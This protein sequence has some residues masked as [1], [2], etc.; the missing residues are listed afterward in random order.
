[1]TTSG[2]VQENLQVLFDAM[3]ATRAEREELY[4]WFH[5]HPELS[6]QEERTAARVE[7]ELRAYGCEVLSLAGT[8]R[9]G[10]LRNG[11]GPTVLFRADMD[12]LPIAE[13]S[14]LEYA[15]AKE[16]GLMHA[17]GHDF[18]TAC[19]LGATRAYAE[20]PAAW[21]GTLIA[22]FQPGEEAGGGAQKMVDDGLAEKIPQPDVALAQHVG[23]F[24]PD[25]AMTT[26]PGALMAE[27]TN[28][29]I[30]VY[31]R[32]G[33]GSQP[34]LST[35]AVVLAAN[36]IT[37]LQTVIAREFDP[38][39]MGILTVGSVHAGASSNSIADSAQL[40][41][42]TRAM[43]PEATEQIVAALK[44]IVRAEC[45]AAQSP[46]EPEF[47]LLDAVPPVHNDEATT[48]RV[49][50]SFTEIF[51]ADAV[52]GN[53]APLTGS[54]DFPIIPHALS[55]PYCYWGWGG[56]PDTEGAPANHSPA[57]NPALQPTLDTGTRYAI[58]GIGL[59]LAQARD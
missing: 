35:D 45:L 52:Y 55:V 33:H 27:A 4:T 12:A 20:H 16:R 26:R 18:H 2:T 17:C 43:S 28:W 10:I 21:S 25:Y 41:I 36:I 29:K 53:M 44:R 46:R 23:P 51:G 38:Q 13:D 31:G 58:A 50:D 11:D 30:T 40:G 9:V 22:L 14:G 42:N 1:M 54:E 32:G 49:V 8:G 19:L 5:Q 59:W 56:F 6:M 48:A 47:E 37:R 7:E 24:A 15:V 34:H 57:F 3:D 39:Q